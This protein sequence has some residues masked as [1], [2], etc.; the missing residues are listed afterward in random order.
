MSVRKDALRC[1]SGN[2]KTELKVVCYA[3]QRMGIS[4]RGIRPFLYGMDK[5][6]KIGHRKP[7]T[8]VR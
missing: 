2:S 6:H 1:Y 5:I 4:G 3:L 8:T 7:N